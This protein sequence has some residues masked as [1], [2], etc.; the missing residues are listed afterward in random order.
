MQSADSIQF[1]NTSVNGLT[2]EYINSLRAS[3]LPLAK[4]YLKFSAP[5]ILF[6]NLNLTKGLCNERRMIIINNVSADI[7]K[8]VVNYNNYICIL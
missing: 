8:L 3:N 2:I 5:V 7:S 4:F 1:D 6:K